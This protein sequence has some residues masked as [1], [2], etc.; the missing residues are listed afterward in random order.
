MGMCRWMGPHF[1]YWIDYNGI[2]FSVELLEWGQ[3]L[4]GRIFW[5]VGS[6]G[7]KKYRMICGTKIRVKYVFFIHFNKFVNP[8]YNDIVKRIYKVGA[9]FNKQ[10]VTMLGSRNLHFLKSD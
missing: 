4:G 3:D 1:H 8:F 5:Q 7:I 2:A 9:L 10:K 6:L